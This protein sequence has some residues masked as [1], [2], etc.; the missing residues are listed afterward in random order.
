MGRLTTIDT[1]FAP[2]AAFVRRAQCRLP[3]RGQFCGLIADQNPSASLCMLR[4]L[5]EPAVLLQSIRSLS[6]QT[7]RPT[8][9]HPKPPLKQLLFPIRTNHVRHDN[10]PFLT[11]PSPKQGIRKVGV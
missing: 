9:A 11:S 1:L 10:L 6:A 5:Y 3:K 4:F 2:V 7:A 8:S